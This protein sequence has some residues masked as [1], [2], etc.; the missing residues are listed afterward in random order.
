LAAVAGGGATAGRHRVGGGGAAVRARRG[1][2]RWND[3][4]TAEVEQHAGG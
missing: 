4:R 2:Q 3:T 1:R